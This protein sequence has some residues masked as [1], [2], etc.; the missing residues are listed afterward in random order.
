MDLL[1]S[2]HL[3]ALSWV[4]MGAVW[5]VVVCGPAGALQD[6]Q[7]AIVAI[8]H[9]P[10]FAASLNATHVLRVEGGKATLSTNM[11]LSAKGEPVCLAQAGT[12]FAYP[13]HTLRPQTLVCRLQ[14]LD[15]HN[16]LPCAFL[17]MSFSR[18]LRAL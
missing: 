2:Y 13:Q 8:T 6:F 18:S 15:I 9:N 10:S 12:S 11:G 17:Q 1:A 3:F 14:A 7:G 4:V 16:T 5:S